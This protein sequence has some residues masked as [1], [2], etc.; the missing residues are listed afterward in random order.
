MI[1]FAMMSKDESYALGKFECDI[2]FCISYYGKMLKK[3]PVEKYRN[4][5]LIAMG[6]GNKYSLKLEW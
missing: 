5:K 2:F 4:I 3:I 1:N 6:K